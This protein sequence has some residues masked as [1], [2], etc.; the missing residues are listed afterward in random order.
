MKK[1]TK[2]QIKAIELLLTDIDELEN[3]P[4]RLFYA[5]EQLAL[6]F[7]KDDSVPSL[8]EAQDLMYKHITE[9]EHYAELFYSLRDFA[10]EEWKHQIKNSP[11]DLSASERRIRGAEDFI[12]THIKRL[13][14]KRFY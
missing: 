5:L 10:I 14:E 13:A 9:G 8:R 7:E 4:R 6:A 11:E 1:Y 3:K 12:K 2:E